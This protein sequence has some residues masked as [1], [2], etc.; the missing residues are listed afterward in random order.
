[1]IITK[2]TILFSKNFILFYYCCRVDN[3]LIDHPHSSSKSLLSLDNERIPMCVCVAKE[4]S[5]YIQCGCS[6]RRLKSESRHTSRTS[7]S[8]NGAVLYVR[9]LHNIRNKEVFFEWL[10]ATTVWKLKQ[11]NHQ[12]IG[13]RDNQHPNFGW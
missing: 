4:Q 8:V 9:R 11:L 7:S 12:L 13:L 5:D 10:I 6:R 1:M 2:I 3:L